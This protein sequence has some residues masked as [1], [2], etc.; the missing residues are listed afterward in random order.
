[1][2]ACTLDLAEVRVG[3]TRGLGKLAERDLRLLALLADVLAD[4]VH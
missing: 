4:G 1:M 2:P 3:D